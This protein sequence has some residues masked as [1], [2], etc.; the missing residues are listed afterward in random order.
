MM[1]QEMWTVVD[2]RMP[3]AYVV[4][5]TADVYDTVA[6]DGSTIAATSALKVYFGEGLVAPELEGYYVPDGDEA[7][8]PTLYP[9]GAPSLSF[10]DME[11]L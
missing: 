1:V 8:D 5:E 4:R 9:S 3:L 10:T 7:Y 11:A 6:N 2:G